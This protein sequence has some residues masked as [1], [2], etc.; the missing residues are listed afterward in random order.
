M[1]SIAKQIE[2]MK[3]ERSTTPADERTRCPGCLTVNIRKRVPKNASEH[4]R[5]ADPEKPYYCPDCD[6]GFD[7]PLKPR[8]EDYPEVD[9]HG[10]IVG[11][12]D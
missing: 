3:H 11:S 10:R 4:Y 9:E 1:S 6:E 7:A 5:G 12:D 2:E 8:D